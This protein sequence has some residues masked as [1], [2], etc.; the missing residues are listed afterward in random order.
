MCRFTYNQILVFAFIFGVLFYFTIV[1]ASVSSAETS[2]NINWQF[3]HPIGGCAPPEAIPTDESTMTQTAA[4]EFVEIYFDYPWTA[5]Q[6]SQTS[7]NEEY[8]SAIGY[9]S[10]FFDP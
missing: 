9:E 3:C 5:G 8:C 7:C 2:C 1:P 10:Y 4:E 6:D